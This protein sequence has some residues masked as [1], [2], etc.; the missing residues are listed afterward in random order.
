LKASFA[1][2]Q[3]A[4]Q[5][6]KIAEQNKGYTSCG[7]LVDWR[8]PGQEYVRSSCVSGHRF[9]NLV[10]KHSYGFVHPKPNTFVPN[11]TPHEGIAKP[12][13]ASLKYDIS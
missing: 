3:Q 12:L 11:K 4:K 9:V 1:Q 13:P 6:K 7:G 5:K 10:H 8:F 2:T